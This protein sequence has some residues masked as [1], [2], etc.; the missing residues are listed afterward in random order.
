[1]SDH[2]SNV[3]YSSIPNLCYSMGYNIMGKLVLYI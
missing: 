1:M 2:I 3:H